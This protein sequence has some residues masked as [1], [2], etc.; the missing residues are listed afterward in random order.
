MN[1]K[2]VRISGQIYA[3]FVP[4]ETKMERSLMS[5]S[6]HNEAQLIRGAFF[7]G[8]AL[9]IFVGAI[10]AAWAI[11]VDVLWTA[12]GVI[13]GMVNLKIVARL[14]Q[15]LL[16]KSSP[17]YMILIIIGKI[18][19]FGI[20]VG[21]LAVLPAPLLYSFLVGFFAFVP[22]ALVAARHFRD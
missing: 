7:C 9:I 5:D 16:F 4:P 12:L 15:S 2:I 14:S 22:G 20:L 3:I 8:A 18:T 13:A 11:D 1:V 6:D 17:L 19:A 10:R 21:V